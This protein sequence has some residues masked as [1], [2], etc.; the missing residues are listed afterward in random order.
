MKALQNSFIRF[1]DTEIQFVIPLYQRTYSWTQAQCKKLWEDIVRV[2]K[3][4][5]IPSHFIGSIVYF[6]PGVY[7]ITSVGQSL[8]IDGQQRLTTLSLLAV[9]LRDALHKSLDTYNTTGEQIESQ[10]L[11]NKFAN[12]NSKKIKLH[13]TRHDK[14]VFEKLVNREVLNDVEKS[15]RVYQNLQFFI[16]QIEKSNINLDELYKGIRKLLIVDIA[17]EKEDNPQLIFESLNSTGLD[18]SQSDLIRNYVLMGLP[19]DLQEEIYTTLWSPMERL[20]I[21]AQGEDRFDYFMRAYLT[22]KTGSIPRLDAVYATFKQYI[23]GKDIKEVVSNVY[24]FSKYYSNIEFG[25]EDDNELKEIIANIRTLKVDVAYPFLMQVYD[26]YSNDTLNK[27]KFAEVLRLVESYVFR[28]AI[29]GIPTNSLNKT[30]ANLHKEIDTDKYIESLMAVLILKTSYHR[31]PKNDEFI[32]ELLNKDIYNSRNSKYIFEKFEYFDNNER[33]NLDDLSVEHIM[34]QTITP[35]WKIALGDD[36]DRIHTDYLHTIG[37]LTLT[38]YNPEMSN[39]SF[40]EKRD[41]AKGF[42]NSCMRLNRD[43]VELDKW[44]ETEIKT[45]AKMFSNEAT[46]VWVYPNLQDEVVQKYKAET[47]PETQAD[48]SR[49]D[50]IYLQGEIET[51]FDLLREQIM[52]LSPD[53]IREEYLAKYIAFKTDK[54]NFVDIVPQSKALQLVLNMKYK[55]IA[56]PEKKT[57]DTTNIGMYGNGDVEIKISNQEDIDYAMM[58]IKQSFDKNG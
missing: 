46:K 17:L 25:K 11:I 35:D 51:L 40:V 37:N 18:L 27:S 53:V 2:A 34:P 47:E 23:L 20:F 5:E 21:D 45:R 32:N 55:E 50:Y 22:I 4:E 9:A 49:E 15:N 8:V 3:N 41:M 36:F 38:G 33:V 29:C 54:T 19:T 24:T 12:E 26:D 30:F 52:A 13:L 31:F 14:A 7:S 43:L 28:R 57:R 16:A 6:T 1:I 58:L 48:Y 56:D 10:F 39:K 42:N 44:G